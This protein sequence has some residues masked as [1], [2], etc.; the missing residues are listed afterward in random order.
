M[1]LIE[2]DKPIFVNNGISQE[3]NFHLKLS[4]SNFPSVSLISI[5]ISFDSKNTRSLSYTYF[6]FSSPIFSST[7]F[8]LANG[9]IILTFLKWLIFVRNGAKQ[10][11]Y[12]I[13]FPNINLKGRYYIL[14]ILKLLQKKSLYS[15]GLFCYW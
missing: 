8:S 13:I 1:I 5:F 4:Y 15:S 6:L 3:E 10:L 11:T 2:H 7:C 12:T 9:H 14:F